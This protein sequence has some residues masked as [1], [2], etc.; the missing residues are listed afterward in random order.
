MSGQPSDN[1]LR[2][3]NLAFFAIA[4]LPIAFLTF[5]SFYR[6]RRDQDPARTAFT[7]L[8]AMLPLQ[9]LYVRS[10]W[11]RGGAFQVET[12]RLPCPMVPKRG[13]PKCSI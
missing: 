10:H 7:Y 6:V 8:K 5:V 13:L 9:F 4:M 11:N 12:V 1:V 3:I 2:G